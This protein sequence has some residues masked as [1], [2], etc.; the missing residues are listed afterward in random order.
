M[1]VSRVRVTF[2][3]LSHMILTCPTPPPYTN[4]PPPTPACHT[5][6]MSPHPPYLHEQQE[7]VFSYQI[8]T[9][10]QQISF[11]IRTNSLRFITQNV[12]FGK[13]YL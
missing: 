3:I 7:E 6:H 1:G 11:K 12:P 9:A 13:T 4:P 8:H 10:L 2:P 5:P